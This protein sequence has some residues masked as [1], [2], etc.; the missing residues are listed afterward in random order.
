MF[1]HE[2]PPNGGGAGIVAAQLVSRL[3]LDK[4]ITQ[5]DLLTSV[6]VSES[7]KGQCKKVYHVKTYKKIWF[8]NY[9]FF[10]KNNV[11]I[12]KYDLIIANDPIA[13]YICGLVL[14]TSVLNKTVCLLHGSEPEYVYQESNTLKKII[15]VRG[16]FDK[17]ICLCKKVVA[18]SKYM[19]KKFMSA[20]PHT[21]RYLDITNCYFGYDE[22]IFNTSC[23]F[24]KLD[25]LRVSLDIPSD[26]KLL[27]T[28]SRIEEKKGF[29]RKLHLFDSII[30]SG[31]NYHWLIIGSGTFKSKFV[32]MVRLLSLE[33]YI[34]FVD[35]VPRN[36]LKLYYQMADL[37]WL[38]SEYRESFGL[39]YIEAQACGTPALGLNQYGVREAIS[40]KTSG[41]LVNNDDEIL[42]VIL[43]KR[44]NQL[45]KNDI[46]YY[47]NKFT[48]TK[49]YQNLIK[50]ITSE[51]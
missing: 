45:E 40:D 35:K 33:N 43:E 39:V 9:Y 12:Y 20:F 22:E 27:L 32:S 48:L 36:D 4:T 37:F 30:K 13:I 6:D 5:L 50:A 21:D 28:V 51:K 10:I 34:T 18:H 29:V 8:L 17:A 38:L 15:D 49:C 23:D 26:R 46:T 11:D 24:D 25:K 44:F 41:Y 7:V 42:E 2:F 1:A 19:Q 3:S 16:R 47:A 14:D 31:E